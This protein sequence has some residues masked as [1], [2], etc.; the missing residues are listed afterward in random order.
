[1]NEGRGE[2]SCVGARRL[3]SPWSKSAL[4]R[5]ARPQRWAAPGHLADTWVLYNHGG[6]SG[7]GLCRAGETL[8]AAELCLTS[9]E[10]Q[11]TWN[12]PYNGLLHP[13][14]DALGI[15][16]GFPTY[17][18]AAFALPLAYGA[19]RFVIFHALAGPILANMLTSNPNEAPAVWCNFSVGILLIG[20]GP[21]IRER[22]EITDRS[23]AK[24]LANLNVTASSRLTRDRGV[25]R[26]AC[27]SATS[28]WADIGF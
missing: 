21:L 14:E 11:I 22:F 13:L 17:L 15:H 25:F 18:L 23:M 24:G 1:M 19:W 27:P 12:I 28:I 5:S 6:A 8:C 7:C 2:K 9:G 16:A 4:L 26:S 10:W 20:L 3:R